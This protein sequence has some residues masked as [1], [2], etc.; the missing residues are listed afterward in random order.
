LDTSPISLPVGVVLGL[1]QHNAVARRALRLLLVAAGERRF[2]RL[3]EGL[4]H[5][6]HDLAARR[7]LV[8]IDLQL[9]AD[10]MQDLHVALGFL[11]I[12]LPFFLQVLVDDAFQRGLVDLDPAHSHA[13]G[14]G[15]ASLYDIHLHCV[16]LW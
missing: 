5:V 13:P 1:G 15:S 3:D 6:V 16:L 7:L 12:L 11:V 8:R 10:V 9:G 4:A 2:H 14:P